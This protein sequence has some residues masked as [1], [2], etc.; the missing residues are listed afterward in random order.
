MEQLNKKYTGQGLTIIAVSIDEK[1]ENM[2]RF[3][4]TANITFATVR[5]AHQKLVAAADVPTMPTS[6]LIDRAG[7]IRFVHAGFDGQQTARLY[8]SEIEQL[9]QESKP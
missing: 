2:Q 4:K 6:F 7:K 5:D 9:L 3:L 1:Q 8:V